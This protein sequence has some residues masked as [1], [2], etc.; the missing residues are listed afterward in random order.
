M[1]N[2]IQFL[3]MQLFWAVLPGDLWKFMAQRN[4][5]TSGQDVSDWD[6]YTEG[7]RTQNQEDNC[8]HTQW[9]EGQQWQ[10]QGERCFPETEI[11]QKYGSKENF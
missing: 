8:G 2:A 3:K 1:N 10:G 5:N 9:R 11:F 4:P 7:I 6:R